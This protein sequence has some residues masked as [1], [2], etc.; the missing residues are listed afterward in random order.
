MSD[1][2][3]PGVSEGMIPGNRP[4]DIE[5]EQFFHALER[6]LA[7][8]NEEPSAL[9]RVP[10]D[11]WDSE[12]FAT[13]VLAAR[14]LGYRTGWDERKAEEQIEQAMA[15]PDRS[16]WTLQLE[17]AR[18]KDEHATYVAQQ[19][20]LLSRLFALDGSDVS[21]DLSAERNG[22]GTERIYELLGLEGGDDDGTGR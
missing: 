14:D 5:E 16:S 11:A 21:I 9:D 12:W 2:L 10:D 17:V 13:A 3:P 15:I 18:V 8:I 20:A 19:L 1:N 4:E 7:G 22:D 6:K